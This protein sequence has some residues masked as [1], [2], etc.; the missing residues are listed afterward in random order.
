MSSS[1]N[2]ERLDALID[3]LLDGSLDDAQRRELDAL[4]CADDRAARAL[5]EAMD[6]H[7]M[8]QWEFGQ[9]EHE[10]FEAA[11]ERAMLNEMF[12]QAL[13]LRRL[14]EVEEKAQAK[15]IAD[16]KAQ[17]KEADLERRRAALAR[18]TDD[19]PTRVIIIPK[20]VAVLGVAAAVMLLAWVGI[21]IMDSSPVPS[22][23]S[24]PTDYG[25]THPIVPGPDYIATL[26]AQSSDA[27]WSSRGDDLVIG[28]SLLAR[29]LVLEKGDATIVFEN[30]A[31]V[32]LTAPAR[33][34]L[35][36]RSA[37]ELH[38][39]Q[40]SAFVP[41][42]GHGFEVLVPGG[43]ITDLGTAFEAIVIDQ[44]IPARVEV[45]QGSVT[46]E[47]EVNGR[48]GEVVHLIQ[49][50]FADV[51]ADGSGIAAYVRRDLEVDLATHST[52]EG[53]AP[54]QVDDHWTI[55]WSARGRRVPARCVVVNDDL[56]WLGA[57]SSPA[58]WISF[59]SVPELYPPGIAFYQ[60]TLFIPDDVDPARVQ[61]ALKFIVDDQLL[62]I[63]VNDEQVAGPLDSPIPH[64][65]Y[66]AAEQYQTWTETVITEGFKHGVNTIVFEVRN[67][68][69]Q[70][71]LR[72]ELVCTG[73]SEYQPLPDSQDRAER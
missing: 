68:G 24:S 7:A 65:Q 72:A 12:D 2:H 30:G 38:Q 8:L 15:L 1:P 55:R 62:A 58:Q 64:L 14:H 45:F 71:G 66:D 73:I 50:Q 67:V 34:S 20:L 33:F 36:S 44:A 35:I 10:T 26:S 49:D 61:L 11:N 27:V 51:Q 18:K 39:G 5:V 41:E 19:R 46:V 52:A 25:P 23:E 13:D 17:K 22:Q 16:L 48:R 40:L 63:R 59:Q 56:T 69:G 53:V 70:T 32:V 43:V 37:S 29:Q 4:I 3:L 54:G 60:T 9:V 57:D 47:P 28:G 31:E 21:L 42:S 6:Q